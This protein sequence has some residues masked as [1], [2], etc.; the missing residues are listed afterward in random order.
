MKQLAVRSVPAAARTRGSNRSIKRRHK[1]QHELRL[2]R[3]AMLGID[4]DPIHVDRRIRVS[5][6]S[7]IHGVRAH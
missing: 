6:S 7:S 4:T 1:E 2:T 5:V 3:L